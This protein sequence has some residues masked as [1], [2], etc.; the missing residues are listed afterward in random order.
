VPSLESSLVRDALDVLLE[1]FPTF[2][3][4]RVEWQVDDPGDDRYPRRWAGPWV[5]VDLGQPS[6]T[7][8]LTP[9]WAVH[10]FAIWRTTGAVHALDHNG[11]V[12]DPPMI[13][14]HA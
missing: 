11:A 5:R 1:R 6:E 2:D 14:V 3:L 4:L 7:I 12:V 13:V 10:R 9:A 8:E